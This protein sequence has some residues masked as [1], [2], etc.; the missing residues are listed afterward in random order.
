[1]KS[2][3]ACVYLAVVL[4]CAVVLGNVY[5]S[6]AVHSYSSI[7]TSYEAVGSMVVVTIVSAG[8]GLVLGVLGA[9][10][11]MVRPGG[12]KRVAVVNGI[13]SSVVYAISLICGVFV[14][15][16]LDVWDRQCGSFF[17]GIIVSAAGSHA[18]GYA[19]SR[20]LIRS[21]RIHT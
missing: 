11:Y 14:V 21:P 5:Y 8:L 1:M 4:V 10:W 13:V 20:V 15:I 6:V 16:P 3:V 18:I 7:Q 9:T 17:L 12:D 19:V 2:K